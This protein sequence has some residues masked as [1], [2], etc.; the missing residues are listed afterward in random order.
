MGRYVMLRTGHAHIAGCG[1]FIGKRHAGKGFSCD[2][3]Y[4]TRAA[5]AAEHQRV[6]EGK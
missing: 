2:K 5:L 1:R 3:D 4:I 6:E